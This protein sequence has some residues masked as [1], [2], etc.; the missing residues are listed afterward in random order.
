MPA[1]GPPKYTERQVWDLVRFVTSAP[2][3]V[4]LPPD[5]RAEVYRNP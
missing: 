2:Y 1:H 5:V 4:R 3:P